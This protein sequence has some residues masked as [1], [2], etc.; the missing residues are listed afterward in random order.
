MRWYDL[1]GIFS[2]LRPYAKSFSSVRACE[3]CTSSVGEYEYEGHGEII[4]TPS[5]NE[6]ER[7][8]H[9]LKL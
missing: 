2:P 7:F 3:R 9:Q 8:V 5:S 1:W 6:N 4:D